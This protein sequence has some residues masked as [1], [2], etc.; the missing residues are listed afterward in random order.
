MTHSGSTLRRSSCD[1]Q[2]V[3]ASKKWNVCSLFAVVNAGAVSCCT[4]IEDLHPDKLSAA[5]L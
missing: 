1:G 2:N 4:N 3:M 5:G